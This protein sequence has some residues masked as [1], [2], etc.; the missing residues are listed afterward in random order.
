MTCPRCGAENPDGFRFCGSCGAALAVPPWA[1]REERKVVTVLFTDLVGFTS[2]AERLDP[3]DV[4]ELLGAYHARLRSE[5]ERHGGT[6]EKFI[7]DA[8]MA[9]FGAPVA[10]EDDPERAVRAAFAIRDAIAAFDEREGR[11]LHVRIGITT[12][13]ALVN[14]DARPESGE[15]MAA[16]DVVNT[17]ARLQA[18]APVDGIYVDEHTFRATER[19]IRFREAEAVEAKGKTDPVPV[20]EALEARA[21][22]GVDVAREAGAPLVGRANELD[23][24]RGAFARTRRER[25]PQLVTLIGVPGIGKSRLVLELLQTVEADPE[26]IVW[27]QGRSLPYGSG[28]TFWALGEMVKAQAGIL[29]TDDDDEAADKLRT[30]LAD[31]LTDPDDSRWVERE[32]RPLVGL[33]R[34]EAGEAGQDEAFAAWRRFFEALADRSPAVVVFEDLHWADDG[35]LD[36]VEQ[37]VDW[38]TGVPLLVVCTSRPELLD[39]RPGWGGGK[40]NATTLS[41]APLT[42]EETA[43]LIASLLDRAVMPAETQA[44]LLARAGGNPLYA[45]EFVRMAAERDVDAT[46]PETVQGIIAARLDGLDTADKEVLQAAAVI[47][48]VFW[49][50]AVAAIGGRERGEVERRL[51]GLERRQFVRRERRTSVGAETE[52][53][54]GHG[55]L[56]DVAYGQIPRAGRADKHRAA[57]AW[58]TS[59]GPERLADRADLL[60][61]HYLEALAFARAAGQATADLEEPA[62]LVLQAAG[63]RAASLNAFP[64]AIHF[65]REAVAL[66][67]DDAVPGRLL[68]EL[69]RALVAGEMAGSREAAAARD[70][71]LAAGDIGGAAEAETVLAE[72][73]WSENR[74]TDVVGHI[75]AAMTLV[76]DQPPSAAKTEAIAQASRYLML[77]GHEREAIARGR[78]AMEMAGRLGLDA[79]R[80]SALISV[81]TA[82]A[83]LGE[84]AGLREIEEAIEICEQVGSIEVI[85]GF[86]N[87]ASITQAWGDMRTG[88]ELHR[89]GLQVASR[90]GQVSGFRFLRA[91]LAMDAYALGDWSTSSAQLEAF[92]AEAETSSPHYMEGLCRLV[93]GLIHLAQGRGDEAV[94]DI[95]RGLTLARAA[96][97]PQ[98]VLPAL[99]MQTLVLSELQQPDAANAALDEVYAS[100]D[101]DDS[102]RPEH[103]L[104]PALHAIT[105]LGRTAELTSFLDRYPHENPWC[106]AGRLHAEGDLRAAAARLDEIGSLPDAARTRLALGEPGA[107]LDRAVAFYR[108]VGASFYLQRAEVVLAASA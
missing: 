87:L 46:V 37:L 92:I 18:T 12:G 3:E 61:H 50:G 79:L 45:E 54:F 100:V 95:E 60:A 64:A 76:A 24:V 5:L 91:E 96:R 43:Q 70:A 103:W 94:G 48:K 105:A 21:R 102:M 66:W 77:S 35:L 58:I 10:H 11:E 57:A 53:A 27:R 93:R 107:E 33:G 86:I 69:G 90:Y 98:A 7:G 88:N 16:G 25:E 36:F 38:A 78:E 34:H 55:I 74:G 39:R 75:E 26:L 20:W 71:L 62:R 8:V 68:L 14:L 73:A 13:E 23:L 89:R 65:Y 80:A 28:A 63:D 31:L 67:P 49:L 51:H 44:E 6:V 108:S 106:E 40:P 29:E 47:G 81:G 9:L 17:A 30:A 97:N 32:L 101:G 85:R 15:G 1:P 59:L 42:D 56:R 83:N 104:Y 84:P 52:Y 72:L 2:Q 4:R 99:A 19:M 41:L 22:L 82:R